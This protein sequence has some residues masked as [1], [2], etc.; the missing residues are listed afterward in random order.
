MSLKLFSILCS[1][2]LVSSVIGA[3]EVKT[4]EIG[5]QAPEFNLKG[6]DGKMYT[7]KSFAK[8]DILVVLFSC[9]HCP[10]AQA[11][12]DRMIKFVN[13]Y[14]SK[15]VSMVVISPN[16]YKAV[17]FSELGYTDLSDS[18]EEMIIRA[19]DKKYNFPYLYDGATQAISKKYGA[20][21]T[22]HAF[23]FD[24]A[25]KLRY[26][27]RIDDN[28][29]IGKEKVHDMK[30]AVDALLAGQ[31]VTTTTTKVFGCSV[32][33]EEKSTNVNKEVESWAK[34]PVSLEK[35]SLDQIKALVKNEGSGKYRLINVWATWCGPCVREFTGLVESHHMYRRRDFE[36]V[37]VSMDAPKNY[38][39]T[40]A[41]LKE[42]YASNK[43]LIYDG[44]DKY[45]FIE[46]LDPKWQGALP[47]TILISPEGKI[48]YNQMGLLDIGMLRKNI[49]DH[50]G[51]YYD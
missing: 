9:N 22:P 21:A 46:A 11:Y 30:N 39:K 33:W 43:N 26:Q 31:E 35:V 5:A 8:A 23:V 34:M 37:S 45:A 36:F 24:K 40:L 19:K 48:V 15:K 18:Y 25:R 2:L 1:F 29:Y 3:E 7:L 28:E 13:D 38:D 42:K 12:E 14:K 41:F 50:V 51:R 47:Y 27:G 32:K 16:S 10:T 44:V 49:A 6:V 20:I 17:Q 4:L